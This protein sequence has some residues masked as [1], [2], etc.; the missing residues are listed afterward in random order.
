MN[1]L[2]QLIKNAF[3]SVITFYQMFLSFDS[4]VLRVFAPGGACR[5]EVRC[6]EYM[7]QSILEYG[8]I[9]GIW[10]GMKRFLSCR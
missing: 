1:T 7:K 9:K 3:V 6:S 2:N 5:Y 4:G 8:L 10:L